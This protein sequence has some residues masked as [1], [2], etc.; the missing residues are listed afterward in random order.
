[1]ERSQYGITRSKQG[2]LIGSLKIDCSPVATDCVLQAILGLL[3]ELPTLYLD[4]EEKVMTPLLHDLLTGSVNV[5]VG[6]VGGRT[7]QL[8]LNYQ[9]LYIE[10]VC[11]V[12]RPDRPLI[13][14]PLLTWHGLASWRW[15]V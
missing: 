15:I 7:L 8:P 9:V 11:F 14:Y 1:M 12:A 13:K 4:I 10:P 2:G 3:A 6:Q 5:V